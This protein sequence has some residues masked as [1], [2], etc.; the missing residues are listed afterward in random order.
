MFSLKKMFS[1]LRS[2][3]PSSNGYFKRNKSY[4]VLKLTK[5]MI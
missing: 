4:S 5:S 2:L 1:D 3:P